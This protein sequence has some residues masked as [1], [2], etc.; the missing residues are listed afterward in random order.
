MLSKILITLAFAA[1]CNAAAAQDFYVSPS[2]SDK[3]NGLSPKAN[4]WTNTGPFKTLTRAQQAIRNLKAAGKFTEAINVYI[5]KGTYQ[6]R[7]PLEFNNLDSGLPGQEILWIGEKGTSIISGGI[8]LKNCQAYDPAIPDQKLSCPLDATAVAAI[9][10]EP[11]TRISGNGPVFQLFVNENWMQPARWPDYSWAHI[12]TPLD[13]NTT[14]TSFETLPKFTG[15]L[16]NVQV[17]SYANN[18]WFDQYN[19]VS[20]IDIPNNKITLSSNTTYQMV[21]GRRFYLQNFQEALNIPGEWFY[22]KTQNRVSFIPPFDTVPNTIVISALT[23][24]VKMDSASH[25]GF[26]N[27]TFS[28][29]V[30]TALTIT[31]SD[32][33]L[34]DN[35]EIDNVGGR[36]INAPRNTN[37]TLSN[38]NIHDIGQGGIFIW[39]GDRPTLKS[40]GNL[41]YNNHFHAYDNLIF[42]TSSAIETGGVASTVTHNLIEKAHGNAIILSGNDH[43]IEKNEITSVCMESGDCAAIYSGRDWTFRGNIIRYNYLHNFSGYEMDTTYTNIAKNIIRYRYTGSRGIYLD[44]AVSGFNIYGN[45]LVENGV[46]SIQVGGGRDNRIENNF[47]KTKDRAIWVDARFNGFKWDALRNSLKTMPITSAL[48]LSRYPELGVPMAHDTWPE[49]NTVQRNVV[50][51]TGYLGYSLRYVVPA[52]G[53]NIGKNVAWHASSDIRLDY[54][55]LDTGATKPGSLW[56]EWAGLGIETNSVNANPCVSISGTVISLTCSNSPLT[57]IGFNSLPTDMGLV[58]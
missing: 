33:I 7:A 23:N 13:K 58:K 51:S 52:K 1:F 48:W 26:K 28:H 8:P 9:V 12:R 20:S 25:I 45:I 15:D 17:H 53:N 39:G 5:G 50:I 32:T 2:G 55:I 38:S 42:N 54:T 27:L 10:G 29:S 35:L 41:I 30:G 44:D 4:F 11:N 14:F 36:A 31:K 21:G 34:L 49:G 57:A 19:G 3:F 16:S 40:S 18:D 47:I 24:L 43:V 46:M 22:D 6:L 56:S 37:V